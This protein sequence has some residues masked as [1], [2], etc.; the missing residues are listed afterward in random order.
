MGQYDPG[1]RSPRGYYAPTRSEGARGSNR[2]DSPYKDGRPRR[3]SFFSTRLPISIYALPLYILH[4]II[5]CSFVR[6]LTWKRI[7]EDI[8]YISE[9]SSSLIANLINI[10]CVIAIIGIVASIIHIGYIAYREHRYGNGL[11][12]YLGNRARPIDSGWHFP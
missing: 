6:A 10:S 7:I 3:R 2:E 8:A 11:F 4:I 1:G 5:V 9:Q 12:H